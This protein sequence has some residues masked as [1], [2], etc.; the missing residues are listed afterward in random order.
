MTR[1]YTCIICPIGCDIVAE[2]EGL[3]V[4]ALDGARCPRGKEFVHTELT[5]PRR[6]IASSVL[7]DGGDLPLV[8]VRLTGVIPKA[9]IFD[10]MAEI[11][12]LRVTAPVTLGDILIPNVL[13]LG[14]DVI[15]TKHVKAGH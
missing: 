10:V 6:N 8:S 2:I 15:A 3:E 5:D 4:L 1:E 12:K 13:G 7:V 11:K 14:C 9:R